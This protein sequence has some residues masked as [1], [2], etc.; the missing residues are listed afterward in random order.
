MTP[1]QWKQ[2]KCPSADEQ[3]NKMWHIHTM[4]YYSAIK[5]VLIHTAAWM[6]LENILS[7]RSQM[8]KTTYCMI[9]FI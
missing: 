2:S 1:K 4:E 8:Q 5:N 3:I 7:E 9:A 6:N